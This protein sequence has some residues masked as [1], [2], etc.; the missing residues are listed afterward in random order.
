VHDW[1][2]SFKEDRTAAKTIPSAGIGNGQRFEVSQGVLFINFLTDQRKINAAYYM[3]RLEERVKPTFRSKRRGR[4]VKGVCF[5]HD[6]ARAQTAV[7]TKELRKKRTE[8]Y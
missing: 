6:N 4:S 5:L 1:S 8:R 3:K 7:A 2:K